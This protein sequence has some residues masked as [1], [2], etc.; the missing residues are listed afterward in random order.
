[1][2]DDEPPD[3]SNLPLD[4]AVRVLYEHAQARDPKFSWTGMQLRTGGVAKGETVRAIADGRR[5]QPDMATMEATAVAFR[6]PADT[7][8]A[9]R[10]AKARRL[11]D[12][13]EVGL[14]A[15]LARLNLLDD[16]LAAAADTALDS[17][18]PPEP[19][20]GRPTG[21]ASGGGPQRSRGGS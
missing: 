5:K 2:A 7:F 8:A 9:Y 19:G 1:M 12:E 6:V 10:L 16:A 18:P 15:A 17:A 3:V 13:S 20:Q 21:Q 11:L 4:Q 14:D